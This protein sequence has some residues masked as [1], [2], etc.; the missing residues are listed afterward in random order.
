MCG[1]RNK[2][3]GVIL[4]DVCNQVPDTK[5][6]QRQMERQLLPASTTEIAEVT[7]GSISHFL[8]F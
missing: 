2:T 8:D 4:L 3:P 6:S 5:N 1:D 7:V